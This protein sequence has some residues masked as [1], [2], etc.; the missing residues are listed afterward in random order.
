MTTNTNDIVLRGFVTGLHSGSQFT[1][2][3]E[4]MSLH[5]QGCDSPSNCLRLVRPMFHG[6]MLDDEYE[7][8]LRLVP[9]GDGC[10]VEC[11]K[12]D[13]G[14]RRPLTTGGE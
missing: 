8:I 4:R 2:E 11:E 3:R 14:F 5:I 10:D 1:D 9:R 13:E 12:L 6:L 7:V